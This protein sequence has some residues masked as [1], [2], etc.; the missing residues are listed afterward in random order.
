MKK[1]YKKMMVGLLISVGLTSS[2]LADTPNVATMT[3]IKKSI[4]LLI[5]NQQIINGQ[6]NTLIDQENDKTKRVEKLEELITQK[7]DEID[8][9]SL[10]IEDLKKNLTTLQEKII[11]IEKGITEISNKEVEVTTSEVQVAPTKEDK[12]ILDFIH[13][14]NN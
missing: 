7:S 14:T 6:V 9:T 1:M 5:K 3:D 13:N 4:D 8:K 11:S 12:V 2:L 10:E